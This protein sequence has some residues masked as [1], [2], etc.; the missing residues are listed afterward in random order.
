MGNYC[1]FSMFNRGKGVVY[2]ALF[3]VIVLGH[4]DEGLEE[5]PMVLNEDFTCLSVATL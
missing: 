5:P 3:D 2:H 1:N 4:L